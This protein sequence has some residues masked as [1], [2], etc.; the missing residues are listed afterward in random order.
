MLRALLWSIN[1]PYISKLNTETS[2]IS[3]NF[4]FWGSWYIF[5]Q[6]FQSMIPCCVCRWCKKTTNL[7][8]CRSLSPSFGAQKLSLGVPGPLH[9]LLGVVWGPHNLDG[10]KAAKLPLLPC[11]D[12]WILVP[13]L[14]TT[15]FPSRY[16]LVV[17]NAAAARFTWWIQCKRA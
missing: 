8:S 17:K 3:H 2:V 11:R 14:T 12:M 7:I 1:F 16:T 6:A 9:M 5:T 10:D 15:A 13:S 4:Y